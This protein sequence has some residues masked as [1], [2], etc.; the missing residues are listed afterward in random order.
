MRDFDDRHRAYLKQQ[1]EAVVDAEAVAEWRADFFASPTLQSGFGTVEAYISHLLAAEFSKSP[2][3]QAEFGSRE[4]YSAY[5]LG[6]SSGRVRSV[7]GPLSNPFA[8]L[9]SPD[10]PPDQW[11]ADYAGTPSIRAEFPSESNYLAFM[12]VQV[13]K[14]KRRRR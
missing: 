14:L 8:G 11:R 5:K 9:S 3:L 4:V 12:Q 1:H 2:A 6:A 10:A 7:A 13:A